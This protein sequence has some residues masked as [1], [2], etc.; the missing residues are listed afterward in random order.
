MFFNHLL[1]C[2]HIIENDASNFGKRQRAIRP[3]IVKGAGG[4][5]Q[6]F[7]YLERFEPSFDRLIGMY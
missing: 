7:F 1:N 4:N 6:Q 3:K 5:V 2:Y